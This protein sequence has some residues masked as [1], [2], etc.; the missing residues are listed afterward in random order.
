MRN[1]IEQ[2]TGER[3]AVMEDSP[4]DQSMDA[5]ELEDQ[6]AFAEYVAS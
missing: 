5:M 1:H 4:E 6:V 2:E 3:A